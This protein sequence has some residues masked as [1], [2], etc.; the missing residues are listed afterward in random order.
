M[1]YVDLSEEA[2]T[3]QHSLGLLWE[4]DSDM[5]TFSESTD[6]KPFT[7]HRVLFEVNS[8]FNPLGFLARLLS[9]VGPFSGS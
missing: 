6:A 5:V 9:K 4:I 1:K 2:S 7:H 8:V 3:T